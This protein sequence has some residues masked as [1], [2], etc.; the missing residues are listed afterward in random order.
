MSMKDRND[1]RL[2]DLRLGC[3][4]L[5]AWSDANIKS[6]VPVSTALLYC[7]DPRLSD[8]IW[9]RHNPYIYLTRQ[10]SY[11]IVGEIF[12]S[13]VSP[14]IAYEFLAS[15]FSRRDMAEVHVGMGVEKGYQGLS[16]ITPSP[17]Q[18]HTS[19]LRVGRVFVAER[20]IRVGGLSSCIRSRGN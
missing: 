13:D 9:Q 17:Y 20:R 19:R 6:T 14:I 11:V 1:N 12:V 18:R 3:I 15:Q 10:P 8:T 7:I 2:K 5:V 4:V 16:S